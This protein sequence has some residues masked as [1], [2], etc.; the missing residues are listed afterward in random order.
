MLT[1]FIYG[2][3]VYLKTIESLIKSNVGECAKFILFLLSVLCFPIFIVI[4]LVPGFFLPFF[5]MC[6]D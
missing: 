1:S 6:V 5:N 4:C 2:C 3:F